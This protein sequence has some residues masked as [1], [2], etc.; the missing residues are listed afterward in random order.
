MNAA[1]NLRVPQA[2]ELGEFY[3]KYLKI[4]LLLNIILYGKISYFNKMYLII[5]LTPEG[6]C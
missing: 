2:M 5:A 6:N 1:L 4:N 3:S